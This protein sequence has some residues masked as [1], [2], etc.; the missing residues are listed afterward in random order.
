MK[1]YKLT[2]QNNKTRGNT[3]W[4]PGIS[5]TAKGGHDLLCS[6]AWIHFY[7]NPLIAVLMNPIHARFDL[8]RLWE[9]ETAGEELHEPLKSGCKTL[10]TVKEIP[11]PVISPI[12]KIAFAILCAKQV[13][14]EEKWNIWADSWLSGK[15]RTTN[16]ASAFANATNAT[17]AAAYAAAYAAAVA[18]YAAAYA[19]TAA[20]AANVYVTNADF[21]SIAQEAMTYQ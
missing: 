20:A 2:D 17:N 15:D 11:V 1:A 12:N 8:P 10:T 6:N 21:V 7:T 9:C 3:V 14:K 13:F 19:A 18:A 16:A 5:H 4:G